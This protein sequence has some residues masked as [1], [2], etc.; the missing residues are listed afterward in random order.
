MPRTVQWMAG[1]LVGALLSASATAAEADLLLPD[2]T[3]VVVT[4]HV[5][6]LKEAALVKQHF[7]GGIGS[8]VSLTGAWGK[9]LKDVG[10]DPANDVKTIV[11]GRPAGFD[12]EKG[13]VIVRGAFDRDKVWAGLVRLA[14]RSPEM[15]KLIDAKAPAARHAEIKGLEGQ[16]FPL[17]VALPDKDVIVLAARAEIVVAAC[18]QHGKLSASL[19]QQIAAVDDAQTVWVVALASDAL[20]RELAGAAEMDAIVKSLKFIRGGITVSDAIRADF[21]LQ[22][23]NGRAANEARKLVEGVKGLLSVAATIQKGPGTL[24]PD[25]VSALKIASTGDAVTVKGTMTAEQI[26]KSLENKPVGE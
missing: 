8:L 22:T 9:L 6:K 3:E 25:L 7:P 21:V 14:E 1:L 5:Q 11:Y 17:F 4:L 23:S 10:I 26:G 13:L 15:V 12:P 16:R 20:K 2:D 18:G 24:L 19:K